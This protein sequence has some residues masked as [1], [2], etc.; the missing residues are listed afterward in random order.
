M[1][2]LY[3]SQ[4]HNKEEIKFIKE[5][6][7]DNKVSVSFKIPKFY[8]YSNEAKVK[9]KAI[10]IP[11]EGKIFIDLKKIESIQELLI[12]FFHELQHCI[13]FKKRKFINYHKKPRNKKELLKKISL[14]LRAELYTDIMAKKHLSEHL[15]FVPYISSYKNKKVQELVKFENKMS[16]IILTMR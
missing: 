13:N 1:N 7:K 12:I 10:C 15:P 5:L 9:C 6:S 14:T 4:K 16:K 8:T 2:K 11:F 3:Y